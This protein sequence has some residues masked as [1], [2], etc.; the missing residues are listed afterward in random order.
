MV[1]EREGPAG[2]RLQADAPAAMGD[3]KVLWSSAWTVQRVGSREVPAMVRSSVADA[4]A[5]ILAARS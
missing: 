1:L 4:R 3:E 2:F 5:R